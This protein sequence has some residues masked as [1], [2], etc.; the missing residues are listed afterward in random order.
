MKISTEEDLKRIFLSQIVTRLPSS[1]RMQTEVRGFHG[2][3]DVVI[4]YESL[5]SFDIIA[6]E[7]KLKNWSQA[8]TQAF[9]YY[10][11]ASLSY[12]VLDEA[13]V[14]DKEKLLI[15]FKKFNIGL[16]T[17]NNESELKVYFHP[18]KMVPFS[19]SSRNKMWDLLCAKINWNRSMLDIYS[20]KKAFDEPCANSEPFISQEDLVYI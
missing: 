6:F 12:V 20:F 8:L 11:F 18:K 3:P 5:S 9:R 2:T 1:I 13:G 19:L 15:E 17:I 16:I 7:L 14:I 10:K 4:G